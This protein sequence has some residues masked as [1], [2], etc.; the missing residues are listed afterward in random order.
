[1]LKDQAG[2]PVIGASVVAFSWPDPT[3]GSLGSEYNVYASKFALLTGDISDPSD[4][5]GLAYFRNL[6]VVG[7]NF[8]SFYLFL[9]VDNVVI[10]LWG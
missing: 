10:R 7:S 2:N 6:T 5:N 3:I 8:H 9:S 4:E 1:M